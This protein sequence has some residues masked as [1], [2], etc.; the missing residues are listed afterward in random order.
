MKLECSHICLP[1][2]GQ[3]GASVQLWGLRCFSCDCCS[4]S[5]TCR[6]SCSNTCCSVG[7]VDKLLDGSC[8]HRA[9]PLHQR[10]WFLQLSVFSSF[11]TNTGFCHSCSWNTD[12]LNDCHFCPHSNSCCAWLQKWSSFSWWTSENLCRWQSIIILFCCE[13]TSSCRIPLC[14][15]FT[16]LFWYL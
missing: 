5:G 16:E 7:D 3:S 10:Q 11:C 12:H 14:T 2:M 8:T 13:T 6:L 9:Q 1:G 15:N 4:T